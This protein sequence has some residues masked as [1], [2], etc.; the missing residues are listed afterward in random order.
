MALLKYS[1]VQLGLIQESWDAESSYGK[2]VD[3]QKAEEDREEEAKDK[4]KYKGFQISTNMKHG[5]GMEK[6][7]T[8]IQCTVMT[9]SFQKDTFLDMNSFILTT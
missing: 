7:I 9:F 2:S 6:G 5:T 1:L 8:Y 3:L 4:N